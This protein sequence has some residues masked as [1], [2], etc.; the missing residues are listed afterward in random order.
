MLYDI[1]SYNM[2]DTEV[3]PMD[4]SEEP[5]AA[6]SRLESSPQSSSKLVSPTLSVHT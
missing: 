5:S 6:T 1:T 3:E 4:T 2:Q